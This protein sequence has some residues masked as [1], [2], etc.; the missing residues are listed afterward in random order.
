MSDSTPLLESMVDRDP[1][2]QLRRWIEDGARHPIEEPTAAVLATATAAGA[3]SARV[4]LLKDVAEGG[5]TFFTNYDSRKGRELAE[6]PRAALCLHWQPLRRQARV[7]GTVERAS[8]KVSD[9]YYASRPRGSRLGAWASPQSAVVEDRAALDARYREAAARFDG[10]AAPPRPPHWGGFVLRAAE[11][12][13]W[14]HRDDRMH[15][16]LRY[17]PDG[18]GWRIERLAP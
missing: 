8:E 18:D 15:D 14:R 17:R 3:P 12:E 5:I 11:F 9:A 16:R 10:V 7:T 4:V 1:F 2:V 13:F 6:N